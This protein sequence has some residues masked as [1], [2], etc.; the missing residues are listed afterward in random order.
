[1]QLTNACKHYERQSDFSCCFGA[2]KSEVAREHP[3]VGSQF[4]LHKY[5]VC[6]KKAKTIRDFAESH[7]LSLFVHTQGGHASSMQQPPHLMDQ[8][9]SDTVKAVEGTLQKH[10][11]DLQ[12]QNVEERRSSGC[13]C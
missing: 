2:Q 1:M 3:N 12:K 10:L 9:D 11:P 8:K 13:S 6:S 4:T 7:Y 5:R